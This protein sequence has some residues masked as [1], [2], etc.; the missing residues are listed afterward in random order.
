MGS[1]CGLLSPTA[2]ITSFSI[3]WRTWRVLQLVMS[4]L[5]QEDNFSFYGR[6]TYFCLG[7]VTSFLSVGRWIHKKVSKPKSSEVSGEWV[8]LLL[9]DTCF[10][11]NFLPLLRSSSVLPMLVFWWPLKER[12]F[13]IPHPTFKRGPLFTCTSFHPHFLTF[14]VHTEDFSTCSQSSSPF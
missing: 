7:Q 4:Q 8:T 11:P 9:W 6:K 13:W 3:S 10:L 5:L 14:L 1:C 12:M 2:E